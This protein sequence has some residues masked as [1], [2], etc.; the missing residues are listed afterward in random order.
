MMNE[1]HREAQEAAT[2]ETEEQRVALFGPHGRGE[3]K[4]GSIVRFYDAVSGQEMRGV[5]DYIRAP[6]PAIQGG[7]VL[8]TCYIIDVGDGSP[9][10]AYQGDIIA[11]VED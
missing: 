5:I 8:S 7:K 9:H 11:V 6:G 10:I 4:E 1:A 3:Y 2:D